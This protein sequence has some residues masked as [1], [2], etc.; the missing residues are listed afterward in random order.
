MEFLYYPL[1]NRNGIE[2]DE[3][4]DAYVT[5]APKGSHR[6]RIKDA[7]AILITFNGDHRYS[8]DEIQ[9]LLKNAS[10][11]FFASQ[12]SVTRAMH[13]ACDQ[14]N[15]QMLERNVDRGYEGVRAVGSINLVAIH[16]DWLFVAQYGSTLTIFIS[17][18][19]Y[20][21]FGSSEGQSETLGQSKRIQ[22]R[23]YQSGIKPGD[24]ILM[25]GKSPASWNSYY[26]AGSAAISMQQVK[27]R[28]LNQV[29][30][31]IEAIVIKCA[32]G[33][34]Q[35][36][37]K[38]WD[39]V[40]EEKQIH[41][42]EPASISV[43]KNDQR[44]DG[45]KPIDISMGTSSTHQKREDSD[46]GIDIGS[47]EDQIK[48]KE[49]IYL[50]SGD[51]SVI[52]GETEKPNLSAE[53]TQNENI[54]EKLASPF[55]I[56]VAR[57]WM[58]MRTLKAK[59]Q[60]G[61]ERFSRK[62]FP[63]GQTSQAAP[64]AAFSVFMAVTIPLILIFISTS[65][66]TRTGKSEQYANYM[67]QAQNFASLAK[68]EKDPLQKH[69]YLAEA[70]DM[71]KAAEA[72]NVTQDSRM[73][74]EQ[75]QFTL[76]EMDLAARLDFRPA[77]T[78][79]FPNGVVISRIQASSSGVYL[80]DRTSGSV[81][82][83]FLNPKG[84]Y[85]IDDQFKCAPG[86]YGLE[87]LTDLVDFVILP[88]NTD[89]YRIMAVDSQGNLLYCR[90]GELAVSRK[91]TAPDNGW[92]RIIG[93]AFDNDTLYILDADKDSIWM[94]AG[95]DPNK[96]NVET[97]TGIVFSESPIKY[98]DQ[99]APD[100]GGAIDLIVNQEDLYLLNADGHM[101]Q[102]RYSADKKVRLTECL[103]PSPYTDNR[104]GRPDKKPWI[105]T[106]AVFGMAQATQ[107]PNASIFLLNKANQSIYQFSFQLNLE[108]VL[109]AQYNKN[110]PIPSSP[111][112]GFGIT[113][114]ADIFLAFDNRLFI[115][116]LQ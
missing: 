72:Y 62:I 33:S 60:Q 109:R 24:L 55:L 66:Y 91:L 11:V 76:D 21:E 99:N 106:D 18:E 42:E 4:P 7:L 83:I 88:A 30:N 110:Y 5:F 92:G 3:F 46:E 108:R 54:P 71:I 89:N 49:V 102:C 116:P 115:A 77:L 103:D 2:T 82:R 12:G 57:F 36:I 45:E 25:N 69:T 98:F 84:F 85:E 112:S 28:L 94:Y 70:L 15:K 16:N 35:L 63:N 97:A 32:E 58:N 37:S 74:F 34:P 65:V 27:Q 67:N 50:G 64:S 107:L 75:A 90:P 56:K 86:P 96:P 93:T 79:F 6:H 104:V 9:V 81:M 39:E 47:S 80:L 13:A 73:L 1:V 101:I 48:P 95:K 52:A 41:Q 19:L 29:T 87:T 8:L 78:Q 105:F 111:P 14:V 44:I 113:P 22:A 26:L 68:A 61:F 38:D 100:L 20:D 17:T 40:V 51:V 114:E 23:F 43:I 10:D 53:K 31:D 59:I